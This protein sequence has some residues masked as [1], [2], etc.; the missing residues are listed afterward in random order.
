MAKAHTLTVTLTEAQFNQ[1][2]SAVDERMEQHRAGDLD[3]Y[4]NRAANERALVN[5]WDR[6]A[7]AWQRAVDGF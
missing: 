3:G 4:P 7:T 6:M 1:L 5:A 2:R